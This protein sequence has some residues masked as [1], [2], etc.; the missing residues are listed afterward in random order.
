MADHS[1]L[2]PS[3]VHTVYRK[4]FAGGGGP[5][6][7]RRPGSFGDVIVVDSLTLTDGVFRW[8]EP[9][10]PSDWLSGSARDSAGGGGASRAGTGAGAGA[11]AAGRAMAAAFVPALISARRA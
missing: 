4:V 3:L 8:T 1:K 9:W 5:G 11:A 7:P 6:T 2:D 10:Q